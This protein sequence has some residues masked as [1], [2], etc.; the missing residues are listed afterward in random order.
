MSKEAIDEEND[1]T[2][3]TL[4]KSKRFQ[5][6]VNTHF[7]IVS[8]INADSNPKPN[9]KEKIS[10]DPLAERAGGK[11]QGKLANGPPA[12]TQ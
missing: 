7:K 12:K 3:P 4:K 1:K 6:L 2:S 9:V 5:H 8:T 10:E 11:Q